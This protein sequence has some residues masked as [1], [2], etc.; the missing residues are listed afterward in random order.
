VD[1]LQLNEI[2]LQSDKSL[3]D[4]FAPL[5]TVPSLQIGRLD[6]T[7]AR[8]QG[9]DWAVTDLDL[10]LRNLTLSHGGWQSQDGTLSM[11]ASEFIYGSL[12]FFDPILNA[13]FSPGH[14]AAPVHLTLG[15]RH[16]AHLRQLA[17]R[18]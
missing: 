15:G 5:T 12:H 16:G 2:R 11:N 14:C 10:S 8:L 18:R 9:P 7:D 6:I 4:F 3:A 13:E 17:A 1:N